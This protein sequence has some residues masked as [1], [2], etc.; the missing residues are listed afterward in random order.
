[1]T[2]LQ[3]P[4]PQHAPLQHATTSSTMNCSHSFLLENKWRECTSH[5]TMAA[6]N[7]FC[8][9]SRSV[10][11]HGIPGKMM[12]SATSQSH[13][14]M[15]LFITDL[16]IGLTGPKTFGLLNG[17]MHLILEI[18][19]SNS[20]IIDLVRDSNR[21]YFHYCYLYLILFSQYLFSFILS[22]EYHIMLP[23][24]SSPAAATIFNLCVVTFLPE[25]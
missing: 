22:F 8:C 24:L 25:D 17:D 4:P 21:V 9:H 1:M 15:N 10:L 16:Y 2:P 13:V 18:N 5:S 7:G 14:E 19:Q 11:F 23:F 6:W 12:N 20:R 3:H